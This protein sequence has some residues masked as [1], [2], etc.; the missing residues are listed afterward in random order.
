CD[1][2]AST[3][4]ADVGTVF[5]GVINGV[6]G[7]ASTGTTTAIIESDNTGSITDVAQ[8][9][10]SL[11]TITKVNEGRDSYEGGYLYI[12]SAHADDTDASDKDT[13]EV[14]IIGWDYN[15]KAVEVIVAMNGTTAVKL[16]TRLK[17]VTHMHGSK[18]GSAGQD[19]KGDITLQTSNTANAIVLL[20]ITA[21]YTESVGA[22]IYV[23]DGSKAVIVAIELYQTTNANTGATQVTAYMT[24]FESAENIDP[25]FDYIMVASKAFA[26]GEG[27]C[28][29]KLS[30]EERIGTNTAV[31]T[32]KE[33][34]VGTE[35]NETF[36]YMIIVF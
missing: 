11:G 18:F 25:D 2:S 1:I 19:A 9:G 3:S 12:V 15:G 32:L 16:G 28:D 14:T 6:A 34:E 17:A 13:R 27:I 20:T 10:E 5:V 29:C 31:I 36:E 33:R 8:S 26:R 23:P 4:A 24:G 7:L 30:F 35:G 21:T 22:R